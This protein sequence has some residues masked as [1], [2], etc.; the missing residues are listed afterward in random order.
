M[1][2]VL[3]TGSPRAQ[4][5]PPKGGK[6]S[7][8]LGPNPQ[9]CAEEFPRTSQITAL[10]LSYYYDQLTTGMY[11]RYPCRISQIAHAIMPTII[12]SQLYLTTNHLCS[13][14]D[15]SDPIKALH[16]LVGMCH[17]TRT[18]NLIHQ[19]LFLVRGRVQE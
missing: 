13:H 10:A 16:G 1:Y 4:T 14:T 15:L 17:R 18:E 2:C 12:R 5:P 8:E 6:E 19:I 7:G 3:N 9:A 11:H